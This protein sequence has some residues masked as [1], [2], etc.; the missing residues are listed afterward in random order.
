MTTDGC[1][2]SVR[3]CCKKSDA[4]AA[5]NNRKTW[6][7]THVVRALSFALLVT[8]LAL[9]RTR[10]VETWN[11]VARSNAAPAQAEASA[12]ETLVVSRPPA[13]I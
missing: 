7:A 4:A 12:R 9:R 2:F 5:M 8:P 11:D 6:R 10:R 13:A 1:E 3:F